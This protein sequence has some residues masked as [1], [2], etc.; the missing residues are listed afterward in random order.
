LRTKYGLSDNGL[1]RVYKKLVDAGLLREYEL[2]DRGLNRPSGPQPAPPPSNHISWRCPICNAPQP[3]RPEECPQCGAIT[4]KVE[5]RFGPGARERRFEEPR[6]E[7][8]ETSDLGKRATVA[9]SVAILLVFGVVFLKWAMH[10]AA[11]VSV[12]EEATVGTLSGT[13]LRFTTATFEQKVIEH[14]KDLPVL[15]Q[16]HSD[17]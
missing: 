12:N 13:V 16:F 1:E 15:V 9:I 5:G 6:N 3:E 7:E 17:H 2:P 11:N 4:S 14:S 10:R 8:P